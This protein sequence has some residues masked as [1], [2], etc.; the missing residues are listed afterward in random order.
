MSLKIAICE[1][2]KNDKIQSTHVVYFQLELNIEPEKG[3]KTES[4]FAPAGMHIDAA[5][6]KEEGTKKS[7]QGEP[8]F[9]Y[10]MGVGGVMM[11]GCYGSNYQKGDPCYAAKRVSSIC[12]VSEF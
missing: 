7:N 6:T 1:R 4:M 10:P 11:N 8:P 2:P 9:T 3:W 5:Y 12:S